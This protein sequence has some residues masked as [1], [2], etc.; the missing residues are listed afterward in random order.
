MSSSPCIWRA[1]SN[2]RCLELWDMECP[3]WEYDSPRPDNLKG[4]KAKFRKWQ[5]DED[6]NHVHFTL[7]EPVNPAQRV[8]EDNPPLCMYGW[9]ADFDADITIKEVVRRINK[10]DPELRPVW[11]SHTF[12]M[13]IRAVWLFEEKVWADCP[14]VTEKFMKLFAQ[15]VGASALAPNLDKASYQPF[16]LWEL[17]TDWTEI[18]DA[19]EVPKSLT[20]Q[21]F[22]DA[23][24]QTKRVEGN[25][26]DIPMDEVQA[27]I[28]KKY[29]GR[30]YGAKVE[31]GER[32][33]LF[34][35]PITGDGKEQD[36][37]AMVTE[38][39]V[40]S[41]SS[42]SDEGRKFWD[43]LLGHE[44]I[45]KFKEKKLGT[46]TDGCYYDGRGYWRL[47]HKHM[48]QG[49]TREDTLLYL[50]VERGLSAVKQPKASASE[51]DQA[52]FEIQTKNRVDVTAPFVHTE[53]KFVTW[54]GELYLNINKRKPMKP[55]AAGTGDQER[56]PWLAEF[57]ANFFEQH[58]N[59][60]FHPGEHYL[61]ELQ[62]SYRSFLNSKPTSGHIIIICGPAGRGKSLLNTFILREIFGSAMDA[63]GFL[64]AGN[65]FNKALGESAIWYVDDNQSTSNLS[66]HKTFSETIKK[67]AATPEV[68][69]TPKFHDSRVI[70]W[71]GRIH[72][73][74]NDDSD[75]ISI[76]PD[77]DINI[78]D[79]LCLYNVN[80]EWEATF[81][82]KTE[83]A[84]LIRK[85]LPFFLR[86]L[87]DDF[88]PDEAIITPDKPRYGLI[89]YHHAGL[90]STARESS[91]NFR[92]AEVIEL[93][94]EQKK[95]EKMTTWVGNSS[96]LLME[97]M[98]PDSEVQGL[99]K[100]Y[101]TINFG[102]HLNTL[103]KQDVW[104]LSRQES[105]EDEEQLLWV[106]DLK[107]RG[108]K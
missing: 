65:G 100:G 77:L 48:W 36:K 55:A 35:L 76:I 15:R 64:V 75:S 83:M 102:K 1:A 72:V 38:W 23:V 81:Y 22:R 97:M 88:E 26:T 17:G 28:E 61:A 24:A 2:L 94:R 49:Y 53:D 99:M 59:D 96:K 43:D 32:V 46:A 91:S 7:V 14:A 108:K 33:P 54:N 87:I 69:Y 95:A 85:E 56:F 89:P 30:L 9:V 57:F 3:P 70:P 71:Y 80:D 101:T 6:T 90:V 27:E 47:D 34:W 67:H 25:Y 62:R 52:L 93:F 16:M 98:S 107:P 68:V 20:Q 42:R 21:V 8:T 12:S 50:R 86:W 103:F 11:I 63:G 73:S 4:I 51:V 10:L 45:Q 39:G 104:W 19:V 29:P 37:G 82:E 74:C 44:F 41:F 106:I 92:L 84:E 13:G 79:K 66:A 31:V 105:E 60:E 5:M 40:Y 18:E 78:K 58:P